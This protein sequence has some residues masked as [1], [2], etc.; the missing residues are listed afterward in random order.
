MD[1]NCYGC[2]G[3]GGNRRGRIIIRVPRI[4]CVVG[5]CAISISAGRRA[6]AIIKRDAGIVVI[7]VGNGKIAGSILH[8]QGDGSVNLRGNGKTGDSVL[9]SHGI[10]KIIAVNLRV[11]IART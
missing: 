3:I 11:G 2:A 6:T 5:G 7:N 4:W 1:S 10:R 8:N 9:R